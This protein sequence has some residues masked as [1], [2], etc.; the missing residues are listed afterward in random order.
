M[1]GKLVG[2]VA[3]AWSLACSGLEI[4]GVEP[5]A[6]P[7]PAV[8]ELLEAEQGDGAAL[9]GEALDARV[10]ALSAFLGAT[11]DFPEW[12]AATLDCLE[13]E[14]AATTEEAYAK[15]QADYAER[16]PVVA[17]VTTDPWRVLVIVDHAHAGPEDWAT[18]SKEMQAALPAD[19]VAT[20]RAGLGEYVVSVVENGAETAKIDLKTFV[21]EREPKVGYVVAKEGTDARW[22]E[23]AEV[24]DSTT[25]AC[26]YFEIECP[27]GGEDADEAE[28]AKDADRGV[29][30]PRPGARAK[31][32]AKA[33]ARAGGQ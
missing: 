16:P 13:A 1:R 9:E 22:V 21:S 26:E 27:A 19:Q 23:V 25:A 2:V 6:P 30:R 14:C 28:G 5:A 31:M 15:V 18:T 24:A 4:P 20:V 17:T 10:A 33:K 12:K 11:T 32:K 3:I 29:R 8:L 7:D